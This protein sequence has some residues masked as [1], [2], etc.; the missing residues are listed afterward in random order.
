MRCNR[1]SFGSKFINLIYQIARCLPLVLQASVVNL[2]C[3]ISFRLTN[4]AKL[5]H[6]W[7]ELVNHSLCNFCPVRNRGTRYV[8]FGTFF[9]K[10]LNVSVR[11]SFRR[12]NSVI[13]VCNCNEV[14]N[15]NNGNRPKIKV[16]FLA[17]SIG[18]V[19]KHN[20]YHINS[21]AGQPLAI[22]AH[23]QELHHRALFIHQIDLQPFNSAKNRLIV[24][25]YKLPAYCKAPDIQPIDQF[26]P[27]QATRPYL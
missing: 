17:L 1:A 16:S 19:R 8:K 22:F 24:D 12:F 14:V 27:F 20:L 2:L 21:I 13:I 23:L 5:D 6:F 26:G 25:H 3:H 4:M 7:E 9:R 11:Y 10:V 18:P 15:R